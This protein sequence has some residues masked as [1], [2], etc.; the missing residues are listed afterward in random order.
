MVM[1]VSYGLGGTAQWRLQ[2]NYG[3]S[4]KSPPA[5]DVSRLSSQTGGVK[6]L[7]KNYEKLLHI[8][9]SSARLWLFSSSGTL[10][11]VTVSSPHPRGMGSLALMSHHGC[12]KLSLSGTDRHLAVRREV[13]PA[14]V[15]LSFTPHCC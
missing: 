2:P 4:R 15:R 13:M 14:S 6:C 10:A 8:W 7:Q 3:S 11:G 5:C 9:M 12:G 1:Q